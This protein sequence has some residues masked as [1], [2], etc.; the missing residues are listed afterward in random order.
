MAFL[1]CDS[2][3]HF[4]ADPTSLDPLVQK[5]GM[6]A[7]DSTN[8][9][10]SEMARTISTIVSNVDARTLDLWDTSTS[11]NV[12]APEGWET[13]DFDDHDW[14]G[15]T[16]STRQTYIVK[17][18]ASIW[19]SPSPASNRQHILVRQWFFL[20][21]VDIGSASVSV[22]CDSNFLGLWLNGLPVSIVDPVGVQ[23]VSATVPLDD[24]IPGSWNLIAVSA[25]STSGSFAGLSFRLLLSAPARPTYTADHPST[26]V[27]EAGGRYRGGYLQMRASGKDNKDAGLAIGNVGTQYGRFY[28]LGRQLPGLREQL[29]VGFALRWNPPETTD[30][31]GSPFDYHFLTLGWHGRHQVGFRVDTELH[32]VVDTLP[33][34]ASRDTL[35]LGRTIDPVVKTNEWQYFEFGVG[36]GGH[37]VI[38]LE[39]KVIF[40]QNGLSVTTQ[41]GAGT[42]GYDAVY[43]GHLAGKEGPRTASAPDWM[44]EYDDVYLV[45]SKLPAP[46]GFLGA[47]QVAALR[48]RGPGSKTE[49]GANEDFPNWSLVNDHP[50]PDYEG[51]QV[52]TRTVGAT[53]LYHLQHVPGGGGLVAA[54]YCIT[55]KR[56]KDAQVVLMP[57]V[58]YDGAEAVAT[59]I[60]PS[61]DFSLRTS[62]AGVNPLTGSFWQP[63]AFNDAQAEHGF[64]IWPIPIEGSAWTP[65]PT[66]GGTGG[67]TG[68]S[69][70]PPASEPIDTTPTVVAS[71][72]Q[73][74]QYRVTPSAGEGY[75]PN[76]DASVEA[77]DDSAWQICQV[78]EVGAGQVLPES[79]L[80][81][82]TT[83]HPEADDE[84]VLFRHHFIL[85][86]QPILSASVEFTGDDFVADLSINGLALPDGV[87]P[88]DFDN[89]TRSLDLPVD[90]LGQGQENVLCVRGINAAP[91]GAF[92]AW[93]IDITYQA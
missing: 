69:G 61:A 81:I 11:A 51:T 74:K 57:I 67:G 55:S 37:V 75:P 45:D 77:V 33:S 19:S 9:S 48:P 4:V 72:S 35:D 31:E 78:A 27:F 21:A 91:P 20:P 28:Y 14:G 70:T 71:S 46:T 76:W 92:A 42:K 60:W 1:F 15:S 65:G 44:Y 88:L 58:S 62:P 29:F 23:Q 79:A 59:P 90:W 39:E 10:V 38:R 73:V 7:Y 6:Y 2:F 93:R 18:S 43:L 50:T 25:Q 17:G 83:T 47:V 52:T 89:A 82:W 86:N 13:N 63:G 87:G 53:D 32:I 84:E 22:R 41:T 8:A 16:W 3:D 64:R 80:P 26:F 34:L 56:E 36:T 68:G 30:F 85:R 54:Q 24:L 12:E 40:D 49:W 66:D 5:W